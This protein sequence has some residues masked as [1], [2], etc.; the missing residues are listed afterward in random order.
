[1]TDTP[2]EVL[3]RPRIDTPVADPRNAALS[4]IQLKVMARART[5]PAISYR[6]TAAVALNALLEAGSAS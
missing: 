4:W 1:M 5:P 6:A 2:I 3:P